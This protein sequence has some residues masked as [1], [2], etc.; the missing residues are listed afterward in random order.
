MKKQLNRMESGKQTITPLI[1]FPEFEH[2]PGWTVKQLDDH[3]DSISAGLSLTQT[4]D[5]VGLKVTRIET[6]ADQAIDLTRVGYIS[7]EQDVSSYKLIPG[8]ILFSNINSVSHI[9]KTAYVD[10]EYEL[11][12]GMNLLRLIVDRKS[13]SPEFLF[14]LLNTKWVR[15]SFRARANKAVNQASINQT[16]LAKTVVVSPDKAE[17]QKI[18]ECLGSLDELIGAEREKLEA[19]KAYKKGL[20][21]QLFP[22]EGETVPR[23]RFPEFR[24][25]GGWEERPLGDIAHYQNG[26]AYE[27]HIVES[28]KYVVVNSRFISTEGRIRKYS[29][30]NLCIA[31]AGDVLMVLSDLPK[32]KALAKCFYVDSDDFYAVNQRVCRLEAHGVDNHFLYLLLNRHPRLLAYDD[33]MNQTHLSKD[34]VLQCPLVLPP[35]IE[36]QAQ[37]ASCLTLLNDLIRVQTE[38]ITTTLVHKQSLMQQLFPSP[39]ASS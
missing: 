30:E 8:D 33:G 3:L 15:A 10:R 21:Q 9:G 31:N 22:R 6:I 28:G 14:Q 23:L 17:Q 29:N 1:R 39:E 13:N 38:W 11:Y 7:P 5:G 4:S 35:S 37:I 18:A 19:L 34:A 12:H 36:E 2:A 24:G 25:S 32:G 26:K 16:E 20:M 27:P